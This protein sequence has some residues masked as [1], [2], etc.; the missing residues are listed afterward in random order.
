MQ[1]RF[2]LGVILFCSTNI[3]N[4]SDLQHSPLP[5]EPKKSPVKVVPQNKTKN[6]C[7]NEDNSR[8]SMPSTVGQEQRQSSIATELLSPHLEKQPVKF[9]THR[10]TQTDN[11]NG[12]IQK[13]PD[14]QWQMPAQ[15][16]LVPLTPELLAAITAYKKSQFKPLG[17]T[18]GYKP[19][20]I[21]RVG[22]QPNRWEAREIVDGYQGQQYARLYPVWN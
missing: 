20:E 21:C 13:R 5:T 8:S 7:Q 17:T 14:F 16:V 19:L 12:T 11:N 10:E 2:I 22:A 9:I 15:P 1:K 4:T 3:I 18:S 6:D